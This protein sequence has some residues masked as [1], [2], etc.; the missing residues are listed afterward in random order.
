LQVARDQGF[1]EIAQRLEPQG[2][3]VDALNQALAHPDPQLGSCAHAP[4]D[5]MATSPPQPIG[6]AF[7]F[8]LPFFEAPPKNANDAQF[9]T[10]RTNPQPQRPKV[11]KAGTQY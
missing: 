4:I 8:E 6:F 9:R 1:T 11:A 2:A 10:K 7:G 3:S 5:L